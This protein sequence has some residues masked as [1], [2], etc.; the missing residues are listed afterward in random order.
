VKGTAPAF[1]G[2]DEESDCLYLQ[3][4]SGLGQSYQTGTADRFPPPTGL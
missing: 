2:S 3:E 4:Y 1:F